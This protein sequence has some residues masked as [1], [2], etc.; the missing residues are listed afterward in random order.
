[1][2]FPVLLVNSRHFVYGA[3]KSLSLDFNLS[4]VLW[5]SLS[6]RRGVFL[7]IEEQMS[8]GLFLTHPVDQEWLGPQG[9]PQ[10]FS[11]PMGTCLSGCRAGPCHIKFPGHPNFLTWSSAG[12]GTWKSKQG[13]DTRYPCILAHLTVG[14]Y[15]QPRY[16]LSLIPLQILVHFPCQAPSLRTSIYCCIHCDCLSYE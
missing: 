6:E 3:C 9:F 1:M 8:S 7:F 4:E 11:L 5:G 13:I 2:F 12:V 14:L 16:M 10:L 15:A